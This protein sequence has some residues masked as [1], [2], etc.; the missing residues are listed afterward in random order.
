M[1]AE[2]KSL[3]VS[4]SERKKFEEK[5]TKKPK[6]NKKGKKKLLNSNELFRYP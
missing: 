1:K 4:N 6:L 5:R 2:H 3:H